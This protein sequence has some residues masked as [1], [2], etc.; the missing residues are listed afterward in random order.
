MLKKKIVAVLCAAAMVIGFTGCTDMS[1]IMTVEG[2][3]LNAGVYIFNMLSEYTVQAYYAS[4]FSSDDSDTDFLDQEYDDGV[5]YS[6]YFLDS[7]MEQTLRGV[8]ADKL[9]KD[10]GLELSD[11]DKEEI[12]DSVEQAMEGY[13]E[14]Y[15][16]AQ[17]ISEESV[18]IC[19]TYDK[20]MELLFDYYYAEGGTEEVT[21]EDIQTYLSENY[22]RYKMISISRAPESTEDEEATDEEIEA[23][24]EEAKALADKYLELAEEGGADG[25]DD[26]I[27]QYEEETAEEDTDDDDS[28]DEEEEEDDTEIDTTA[29]Y[30]VT[31]VDGDGEEY[32]EDSDYP[33]ITVNGGDTI[34][35]PETDPEKTYYLFD[36]WYADSYGSTEF[37]F[38]E[39]ITADTTVYACFSTNEVLTTYD[40]DSASDIQTTINEMEITGT[41]VLESDDDYYYIILKLDPA[42]REDYM[43]GGTNHDSIITTMKTDEFNERLDDTADSMDIDTNDK[44]VD[45]YTPEKIEEIAEE[46]SE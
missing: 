12:A 24:E 7:A 5:T 29:E 32:D 33:P 15:L 28:T 11:E 10:A 23:A 34:T 25:F 2:E 37:D 41:P 42:E 16:S 13:G 46:Y 22:L 35:K 8:A 4:Y 18:E 30:T 40:E 21:D 44:A 31:F 26:V 1:K 43:A 20:E 45:K 27:A 36:G 38:D 3:E 14:D 17:G 39:P 19:Y 9:F 6:E